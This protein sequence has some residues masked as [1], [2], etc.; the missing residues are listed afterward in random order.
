[1]LAHNIH[2]IGAILREKELKRIKR[3]KK[4]A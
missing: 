2:R 4:A 1:V 3:C